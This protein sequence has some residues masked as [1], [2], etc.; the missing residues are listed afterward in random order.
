MK[1]ALVPV[2]ISFKKIKKVTDDSLIYEWYSKKPAESMEVDEIEGDYDP[3][4]FFYDSESE[5]EEKKPIRKRGSNT[6]M[7]E[8]DG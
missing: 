4:K 1:G 5:T 7:H 3:N 2:R 8:D 6:K